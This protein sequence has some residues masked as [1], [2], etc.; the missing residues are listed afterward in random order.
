MNVNELIGLAM[1]YVG[2]VINNTT[3]S[4]ETRLCAARIA[5]EFTATLAATR[6]APV[7]EPQCQHEDRM[8]LTKSQK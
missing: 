5:L 2:D 6:Q 8:N 4:D 7:I 3:K 1:A